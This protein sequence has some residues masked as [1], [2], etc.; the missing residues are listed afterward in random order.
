MVKKGV[1]GKF[2]FC[3]AVSALFVFSF[4]AAFSAP[5]SPN[6]CLECHTSVTDLKKITLELE[7][8]KPK[9]SSETAGE[10]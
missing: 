6:S 9:K 4:E 2:A 3:L 5:S 10:G 8:S 7:K 1:S